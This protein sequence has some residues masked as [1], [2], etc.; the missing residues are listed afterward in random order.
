MKR[1]ATPHDALIAQLAEALAADKR[2]RG[3][4]LSGSL[5]QGA[6]DEHSD[7][8]IVAEIAESDRAACLTDYSRPRPG[9]PE[10][11]H[12]Q[13]IHGRILTAIAANWERFDLMFL[14]A[15]EMSR[16]DGGSLKHLLGDAAAT[17]PAHTPAPPHAQD[18]A[19]A[20]RIEA[21][22]SEFLR[23]LGL[24][25]VVISREE[26]LVAQQGVELLRKMLIDTMLE[27]NRVPPSARGVKR[28]NPFLTQEQ[29]MLLESLTPPA[30]RREPL[31]AANAELARIFLARAK[32]LAAARGAKWPQAFEDSTRRH[33]KSALALEI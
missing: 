19:A 15:G 1:S 14:T 3:A 33:L 32:P 25:V 9:M 29:R 28:L 11:V 20:V 10:T 12:T 4:W 8:D 13:V 27:E 26:W 6:G 21:T 22:T 2:I 5:G 30:A 17:P 16:I 31:L 23:V 24:T 18:A 7:V